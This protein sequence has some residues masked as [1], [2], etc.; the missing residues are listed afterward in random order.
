LPE[1]H[2]LSNGVTLVAEA[3]AHQMS[4]AYGVFVRAGSLHEHPEQQGIAHI[5]EH[6]VF[7]GTRNM[8]GQEIAWA[9][10]GLG[11]DLNAYTAKEFT[12]FYSRVLP[13]RQDAALE[14]LAE[15]TVRPRFDPTDLAR[16]RQVV[17]EEIRLSEDTPD[18]LVHDLLEAEVFKGH[19]LSGPVLGTVETVNS[20]DADDVLSF[21]RAHYRGE[22]IVV[23]AAGRVDVDHFF[24]QGERLFSQVAGGSQP[25]L[26]A[27]PRL[28]RGLEVRD[29]PASE[30]HLTLGGPAAPLADPSIYA[31]QMLLAVLGGGPS[32]RLFRRLRE[33]AGISYSVYAYD[34]LYSM[35]GLFGIYMDLAP[36]SLREAVGILYDTLEELRQEEV[37]A[38]ELMRAEEQVSAGF[39]LG[40]ET[41]YNH[42]ERNAGSLLLLG[43]IP[44][45]NE[46]LEALRSVS[47]DDVRRV[48]ED[49][50]QPD[51][52]SL[53]AVGPWPEGATVEDWTSLS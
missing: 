35:A 38:E 22:N 41:A 24:H 40:L 18:E 20:F 42:M 48:A 1:I 13:H 45:P 37:A 39:I 23:S 19:A 51:R 8:S 21:Y 46:V 7:K 11:G 43:R 53:A 50:L 32:S 9:I 36:E 6:M 17:V 16:E 44:G 25:P 29:R 15:L 12:A 3:N 52:L 28:V 27:T 5:I 4:A 49:I 34:A 47:A 31:V 30:L 10:D 33:D 14:L 2:T 26:V